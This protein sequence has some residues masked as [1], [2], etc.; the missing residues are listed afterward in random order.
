MALTAAERQRRW[1]ASHPEQHA[2]QQRLWRLRHPERVALH[3]NEQKIAREFHLTLKAAREMAS[4]HRSHPALAEAVWDQA[5]AAGLDVR[6]VF[7]LLGNA[8]PQQL[9]ELER[10]LLVV[11]LQFAGAPSSE[12]KAVSSLLL[13]PEK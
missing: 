2:E 4:L 1:R 5:S 10:S 7:D 9:A 12:P 11:R 3:A 13:R 6:R 8:S